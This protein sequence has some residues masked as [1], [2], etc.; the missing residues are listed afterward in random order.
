MGPIPDTPEPGN[1][2]E[3]EETYIPNAVFEKIPETPSKLE[4]NILR[5]A[6]S[7]LRI[8]LVTGVFTTPIKSYIA[9][10]TSL[11]EQLRADNIILQDHVQKQTNILKRRQEQQSG[12]RL[13]LE[14]R[15]HMTTREVV[16]AA[17]AA[18]M[19][20]ARKRRKTGEN[21][22]QEVTSTVVP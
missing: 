15:M 21:T 7:T 10:L 5:E 16:D 22:A 11:T 17:H 9:R 12:K 3:S 14:G 18:E 1:D 20:T 19:T 2:D 4:P 8:S 13:A 6:N